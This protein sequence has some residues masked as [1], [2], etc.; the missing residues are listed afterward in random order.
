MRPRR[1]ENTFIFMIT[2]PT[3]C[4]YTPKQYS[5]FDLKYRYQSYP[6]NYCKTCAR[7]RNEMEFSCQG[8]E[9]LNSFIL[10]FVFV[11]IIQR[12]LIFFE[13]SLTNI[14]KTTISAA[15]SRSLFYYFSKIS[16]ISR[17]NVNALPTIE[18]FIFK[19]TFQSNKQTTTKKKTL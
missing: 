4:V 11:I 6:L 15:P 3:A 1:I 17:R 19:F 7:Y 2:L 16:I 9:H 14:L 18:R 10:N 5:A 8:N 13:F 12:K